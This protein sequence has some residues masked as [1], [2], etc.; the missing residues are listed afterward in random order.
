MLISRNRQLRKK[1]LKNKECIIIVYFNI[2]VDTYGDFF[3]TFAY[4][5]E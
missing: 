1:K 3:Y 4:K 2:P 5:S